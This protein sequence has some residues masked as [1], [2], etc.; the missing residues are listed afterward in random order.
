MKEGDGPIVSV[1]IPTYNRAF[2]LEKTIR[3]VLAQKYESWELIVVDDG[4]TD[5][6][7]KLMKQFMEFDQRIKYIRQ[8]NRGES[9]AR[10]LGFSIS[11]GEFIAFLDSDDIWTSDNLEKK[12]EILGESSDNIAGVFSAVRLIDFEG[13]LIDSKLYGVIKKRSDLNLEKFIEGLPI[14]GGSS[15]VLLKRNAVIQVGGFDTTIKYGEDQKFFLK[16]RVNFLFDYVGIPLLHY[17][18]HNNNQS[19]S[20]GIENVL[21]LFENRIRIIEEMRF[22]KQGIFISQ[23]NRAIFNLNCSLISWL[24][25]YND[26][27]RAKIVYALLGR[28]NMQKARI[29]ADKL[30]ERTVL[31]IKNHDV[32]N[33]EL[34]LYLIE[35]Q[36]FI[37]SNLDKNLYLYFFF[38]RSTYKKLCEMR[39]NSNYF[40]NQI[41]RILRVLSPKLAYTLFYKF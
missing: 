9:H 36:L 17:R 41:I 18:I 15:N 37:A 5:E 39:V 10:N 20:V 12:V 30:S 21:T 29:L 24:L 38:Y 16:L 28:L 6:T 31:Y 19:K 25:Y 32:K 1:I 14:F 27:E 2:L 3:S 8:E 34:D 22:Y 11:V 26:N 33:R 13:D 23:V 40:K 7:Y 35:C 4:S